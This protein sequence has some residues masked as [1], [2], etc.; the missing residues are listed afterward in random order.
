MWQDNAVGRGYQHR[1]PRTIIAL[2]ATAFVA[3]CTRDVATSTAP[4]SPSIVTM[5]GRSPQDLPAHPSDDFAQ[6]IHGFGGV[7]KDHGKLVVYVTDMHQATGA[8]AVAAQVLRKRGRK[9]IAIEVRQGRYDFTDLKRWKLLL[10]ST[11][12]ANMD[13]AG[14]AIDERVNAIL[15]DVTSASARV[16]V[17][18]LAAG[19]G[20][21]ASA[22]EVRVV[23]PH[24]LALDLN[25]RVRPLEGGL[26]IR[27][28]FTGGDGFGYTSIC[29]YGVNATRGG[30]RYMIMNSHCTQDAQYY[31]LGGMPTGA[32]TVYQGPSVVFNNRIGTET[33][34]PTFGSITGC[35]ADATCR[36]SDAALVQIT[37]SDA[38]ILG[39]VEGTSGGPNYSSL[40][41][42]TTIDP[43]WH[44]DL[45]GT[46][47]PIVGDSVE[48]VGRVSGWTG[49][50]VASTCYDYDYYY[51][52]GRNVVL[53]SVGV[54]GGSQEGDSGA[55]VFFYYGNEYW[56]DGILFGGTAGNDQFFFAKWADVN[57]ELGGGLTP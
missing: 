49:G 25:D 54:F 21:P 24:R 27:T 2:V 51:A 4:S 16:T 31:G 46:I 38:S 26:V 11:M 28:P 10:R 52:F 56:L 13:I 37:T 23:S 43:A 48:K 18:D 36:R 19:L 35:P 22:L 30:T 40:S 20:V 41:G 15:F 8:R 42:P 45:A 5:L 7:F 1:F 6:A 12:S 9:P 53:C 32:A 47:T 39:G 17:L 44:I 29:T 14:S 33:T 50:E 34:D 57:S 55:P 3:G